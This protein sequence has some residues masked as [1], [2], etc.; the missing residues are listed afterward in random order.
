ATFEQLRAAVR[1]I[2][3]APAECTV[4]GRRLADSATV[5]VPVSL[6]LRCSDAEPATGA[7]LLGAAPASGE[8]AHVAVSAPRSETARAGESASSSTLEA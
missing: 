1:V 5:R 3:A 6:A 4:P 7:L 2:V 8:G